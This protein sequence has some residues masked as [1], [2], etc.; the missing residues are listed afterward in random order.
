MRRMTTP[1]FLLLATLVVACE[2][3]SEPEYVVGE[4]SFARGRV[5]ESVTGSGHFS[6]EADGYWR[7]F[8]FTARRYAD[9]TVKGRW[10]GAIHDGS[11]STGQ[12]VV[13]CFTIVE[14]EAWLGGYYLDGH[15]PHASPRNW[16]VWR[17]K[18]NGQGAGDP[19]RILVRGGLR[20]HG[21]DCLA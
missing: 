13:T 12:G 20:R 9:G 11:A 4:P 3:V 1:A 15:G 7:T 18:D 8:S 19:G 21:H 17:V 2:P 10:Q 5:L 16:I 14:N 6:V